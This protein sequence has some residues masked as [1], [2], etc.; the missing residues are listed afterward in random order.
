MS[1]SLSRKQKRCDYLRNPL[2]HCSAKTFAEQW[3]MLGGALSGVGSSFGVILSFYY[4]G[5][6]KIH[7]I[8]STRY[9]IIISVAVNCINLMSDNGS[10][11]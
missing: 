8:S 11:L 5:I 6:R 1:L 7:S 10:S 9:G 3:C 2:T 4:G